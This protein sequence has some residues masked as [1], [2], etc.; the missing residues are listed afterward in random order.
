MTVRNIRAHQARGLLDP[1]EVRARVGYYGPEHVAQLRLI[2]DLQEDGF[3]LGGIKRLI[4]DTEGTAERLQRFGQAL[5]AAACAERGQTLTLEELGRRF[6]VSAQDGARGAGRGRA[7]GRA[8]ARPTT[9]AT[10]SRAPRCSRSP[11]RSVGTRDLARRRAGRAR[12]A[13]TATAS[14]CRA[15]SWSCSCTRSGSRSRRRHARRAL[16]GDRA[17]DAAARP[18]ASEALMAIFQRRL[19]EQI[20]DAFDGDRAASVRAHVRPGGGVRRAAFRSRCAAG[21]DASG[22][23]SGR[24]PAGA[25]GATAC[26]SSGMPVSAWM[27]EH[28][29]LQPGQRVLELAAGPGDTGFLAAELIRPGGTLISSDGAESMLE[30]ARARAAELGIENVEFKRIEL[31]WI[32]LDTAERRRRPVQV[33]ADVRRRSRG[34]AAGGAPRAAARRP[35]RARRLGRAAAQSVG[36]DPRARALVELGHMPRRPIPTRP[37]MFACPRRGACRSCS[38]R[39]GSSR[40]SWSR[41]RRPGRSPA[42]SECVAETHDLSSMFGEVF[43]PLSDEQRE[44]VL[45]A[46]RGARAAVHRRGR[47]GAAYRRARWWPRPTRGRAVR[48]SAPLN[49]TAEREL[50]GSKAGCSDSGWAPS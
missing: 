1:P 6:R 45:A 20:E 16:A 50:A 3:N 18:V 19:R 14:R 36:H 7:T 27:I 32:D 37:G 49:Q 26:A 46:D 15:R 31:E 11:R 39:P 38:R 43:D 41:C 48:R 22:G 47:V 30:V 8:R 9:A 21:R 23:G 29:G 25:A 24:R 33:G 12:G 35:R 40:C 10:R 28:A 44:A 4:D 17:R 5:S 13:S 34:R 42:S 2:R